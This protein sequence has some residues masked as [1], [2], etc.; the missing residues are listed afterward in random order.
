MTRK[1]Y[2]PI[3]NGDRIRFAKLVAALRSKL[4]AGDL[5]NKK[6]KK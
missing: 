4:L 3:T 1:K 5:F 2:R 6:S